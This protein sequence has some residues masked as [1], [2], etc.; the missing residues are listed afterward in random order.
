MATEATFDPS[1]MNA[2]V[3]AIS[4]L[5]DGLQRAVDLLTEIA[6]AQNGR[7]WGTVGAASHFHTALNEN[8]R[9]RAVAVGDVAAYATKVNTALMATM[10]DI[11]ALDEEN[12]ARYETILQTQETLKAAVTALR[13]AFGLTAGGVAD[14]QEGEW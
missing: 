3:N 8:V 12:A 10:K 2:Q 9:E 11:D 4:R 1:L 6:E 7:A 13:G 14:S 5:T